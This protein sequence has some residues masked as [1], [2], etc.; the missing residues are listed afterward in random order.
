MNNA[1]KS[2]RQSWRRWWS[3]FSLRTSLV[4]IMCSATALIAMPTRGL[5]ADLT[6]DAEVDSAASIQAVINSA[7]NDTPYVI[8]LTSDIILK[9]T[10]SIPS[11]R[12]IV[13]IGLTEQGGDVMTGDHPESFRQ[14]IIQ[15]S[16]L[17]TATPLLSSQIIAPKR[18]IFSILTLRVTLPILHT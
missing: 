15:Y 1:S 2:T 18:D 4:I 7:P 5:M 8:A 12:N 17:K 10:P 3:A 9:S 11:G 13:L 14:L 16:L 6:I